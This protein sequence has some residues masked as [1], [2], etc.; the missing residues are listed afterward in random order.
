M[1][2]KSFVEAILYL[3]D[4]K[5]NN[6]GRGNNEKLYT[7]IQNWTALLDSGPEVMT[8]VM[9]C[10][11]IFDYKRSEMI[12]FSS[13]IFQLLGIDKASLLG[14][15]GI[16]RFMDLI[17]PNDFKVYNDLIFPKDM[18][19]LKSLSY[20]EA[21]N[22]TFSNNFRIKHGNG[23]YKNILMKKA[24]INDRETNMPLFELG[25]LIDISSIKKELSITHTIERLQKGTDSPSY[26]KVL[27]EDYFPEMHESILSGREKEILTHLSM[28]TKRKEVGVKL[29]ISDNTVA[30]HIKTILRKTNSQNIREAIAICKMNGII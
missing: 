6:N 12:Y 7:E 5:K 13:S 1:N 9:P 10:L 26:A 14:S 3:R 16:I 29:F 21:K 8:S 19:Y 4:D 27:S 11:F 30:N 24:F 28:G 15:N 23:L 2:F 18:N 22:V 20:E 17:N 25:V